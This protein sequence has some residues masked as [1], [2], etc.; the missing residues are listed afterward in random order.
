M[1]LPVDSHRVQLSVDFD[2]FSL[3]EPAF[4][5]DQ[6]TGPGFRSKKLRKKRRP[7]APFSHSLFGE[8]A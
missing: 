4:T 2:A 1:T 5:P 3:R 8:G 7:K 6:A